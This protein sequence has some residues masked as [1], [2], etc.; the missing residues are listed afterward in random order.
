MDAKLAA[1]AYFDA[2][3]RTQIT[4]NYGLVAEQ[5]NVTIHQA[6]VWYAEWQLLRN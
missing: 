2:C 5:L 3:V 1:F 4:I 6:R